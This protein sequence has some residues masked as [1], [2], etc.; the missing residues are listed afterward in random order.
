MS[1]EKLQKIVADLRAPEAGCPWDKEQDFKSIA[2]YTLE[3]AYEVIDAIERGDF[4][5]LKDE[6]GDLLLQVVF[7]AQMAAEKNLFNLADVVAVINEK[8][9]RRHPHVFASKQVDGEKVSEAS[10]SLQDVKRRWEAEKARERVDKNRPGV[11]EGIAKALPALKRAQ[12]LQKRAASVGFDWSDSDGPREK[13]HEELAELQQALAGSNTS[14]A[15]EEMG[16]LLFSCVNLARHLG[17]DAESCL[18]AAN[19]KFEGRFSALERILQVQERR[20][21]ECDL[22]EL[23]HLWQKVKQ[24]DQ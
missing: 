14:S 18:L 17:F 11:L 9:L 2:A 10:V 6:L 1:I 23:E 20:V 19:R 4:E 8:M 15:E 21:E 13:V 16:D 24:S 7:H 5:E 22:Q 12:K 3:E